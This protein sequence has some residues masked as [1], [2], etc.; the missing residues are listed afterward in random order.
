MC[1]KASLVSVVVKR[2]HGCMLAVPLSHLIGFTCSSCTAQERVG[3]TVS[4]TL[5]LCV[6]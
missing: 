6:F 2:E 5:P 4:K 3:M 1:V